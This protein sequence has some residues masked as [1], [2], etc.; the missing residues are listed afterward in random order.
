MIGVDIEEI[1]RFKNKNKSFLNK[2]YT[3]NEIDYCYSKTF[4]EQHLAVRFC[5]KEAVI[6]AL[7]GIGLKN[8]YMKD[9]EV[10]HDNN[11][12]PQIKFLKDINIQI[13]IS[14]SH[15]KTKAIAFAMIE[16]NNNVF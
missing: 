4:P 16:R 10:Y 11:G 2:I 7:F 8:V 13:K 3:Q 9:I 5:A 15:D 14:L 1:N 6:K 12:V